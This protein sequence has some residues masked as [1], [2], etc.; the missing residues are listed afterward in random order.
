MPFDRHRLHYHQHKAHTTRQDLTEG[1]I[2]SKILLF[3]FPIFLGNLFQQFY[4]AFDSWCVGNFL[5]EDALAG[6]CLDDRCCFA[7]LL[8]TLELLGWSV[9]RN[10][11]LTPVVPEPTTA[12]LSLLAL[13]AL[14]AHRRRK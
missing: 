9:N 6:K 1:P 14:A 3:A 10:S 2:W 8:R 11:N 5:G 13:A 12:T 4:N 7:L